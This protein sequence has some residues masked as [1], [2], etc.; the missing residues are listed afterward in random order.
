MSSYQEGIATRCN[1]IRRVSLVTQRRKARGFSNASLMS[2]RW[3][4]SLRLLLSVLGSAG[5]APA[6][7]AQEASHTPRVVLGFGVDTSKAPENE[8]MRLWRGYL[9]DHPEST[10]P[11]RFWSAA[12]QAVFADFDIL[13]T[14]V[15]Q[16]FPQYTVTQLGPAQG[17]DST[18][19]LRTLVST[20][21]S[22]KDVR[23]LALFRVYAVR[24]S[25]RWV[26]AN[27]L[28]R[29]TRSWRRETLGRVTFIFPPQHSFNRVAARSTA[30]FVDS[31]AKAFQLPPPKEIQ[32]YFT[33]NLTETF[34]AAG[35]EF[36][37]TGPDTLG[38]R[39]QVTNHLVLVGASSGGESYRHEVAHIVLG[40]LVSAQTN[41]LVGEGLATWAG[42]SGGLDYRQ[43]LPGLQQYLKANPE[44]S[45]TSALTDPPTRQGSL[46]VGYDGAAVLCEM[47]FE[48]GGV[49][50]VRRLVNAGQSPQE[51]LSVA[52][53]ILGLD[54]RRLEM[55][56]RARVLRSVSR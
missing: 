31:L 26:L 5:T 54:R 13:R 1:L 22:A 42:G 43:L 18:Y 2:H 53:R 24:E 46:D 36:F 40:S 52:E 39:A 47:V 28:P 10:H 41:R 51:V 56:W 21:D 14:Y 23:P 33:D 49:S 27:A 50:A 6:I 15:F 32:Y 30:A 48:K 9:A 12:E 37:P 20:V 3:S 17:L 16:G 8:I 11:S 44:A 45:L 29:G 34:R 25:G 55:E 7:Q 38:G 19:V 35:L 4:L